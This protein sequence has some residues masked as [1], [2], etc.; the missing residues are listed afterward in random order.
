MTQYRD[1]SLTLNSILGK[2]NVKLRKTEKER[3]RERSVSYSI[4]ISIRYVKGNGCV[5]ARKL[6][7]YAVRFIR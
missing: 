3:K 2:I 1:L 7:S 4:H 6:P 5:F